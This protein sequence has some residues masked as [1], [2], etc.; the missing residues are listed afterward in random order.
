MK[1][2]GLIP[3]RGG[4]KGI[5]GKNIKPLAG[6]ALICYS[7]EAALASGELTEVLVSTDSEAIAEQ[8]RQ[9]GASVPFIRPAELA[10]DRSPTIDTV[11]HALEFCQARGEHYD[12]LCLLQ[13]TCPF[14]TASA[15]REAIQRFMQS[16]A[17]S[18]IS[19]REVPHQYNP[20]WVFEPEGDSPFL[21]IATGEKNIIP[22]RQ[23]LPP[24][25]HRDGSIYITRTEVLLQQ[26]SLYGER[27]AYWLNEEEGHVNIDTPA[28]WAQA[29]AILK[30]R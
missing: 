19:V 7:I 22:R 25:Y 23:E 1:V 27:T 9:A 29:E 16:K 30:S 8:S 20:H 4:S 21:K 2:L 13:P 5:P 26:R 17:D 24:A 10:S 11:I 3:A 12:A 28:D 15:I 18:L 14:R 6:K